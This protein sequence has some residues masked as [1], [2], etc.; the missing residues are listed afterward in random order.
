[1]TSIT[2][3]HVSKQFTQ[4]T[5]DGGRRVTALHDVSLKIASG[6]TLS[7]LGPSGCGK[8]TL[9]RVIAGLTS[10]DEGV[11]LYD[12]VDLRDIPLQERGV[13]MVFQEGAL[14]PHWVAEQN[15]G[16]H[17]SL[18]HREDEVP[19]RVA[20]ISQITG[21][22]MEVLLDRKPSQLSG[23]ERQRVGIARA[24]ARD[25]RV[26]LFDEPFSNLDAKLR[27][28]ARIE[29]HRLLTEFPVTAIYVTHD[30]G[31]ASA[32]GRRVAVMR[33]GRIEQID[34]YTS[35]Y[36]N[37]IN[38]F[39]ATFIGT[40]T[41]NLFE[42]VA[43]GGQWHGAQFAGYPLRPDLDDGKPVLLGVRAENIVFSPGGVMAQVETA[44][45]LFEQRHL[46]LEMRAGSERFTM[47]TDLSEGFRPG[48]PIPCALNPDGVLFFD[49]AT[50]RRIG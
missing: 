36:N 42:G 21:F 44:T 16:F 20:R 43:R 30:Q 2:V 22:G 14:I 4:T 37:P 27:S 35:L 1:V 7:I 47:L 24:M 19:A 33:E 49:P 31:E 34:A 18:R 11:V 28:Q 23:G 41:I 5:R 38:L 6:E 40:P 8:S 15:I 26:F 3:Q 9:L 25:P 46:V 13:G 29:L 39:V 12:K 10:P 32:L 45:P 17:L 50:G 48:D